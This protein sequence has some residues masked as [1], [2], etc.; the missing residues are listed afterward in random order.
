ML[1]GSKIVISAIATD[2]MKQN[3][4]SDHLGAKRTKLNL[5]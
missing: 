5:K 1:K 3:L 2:K 4:H